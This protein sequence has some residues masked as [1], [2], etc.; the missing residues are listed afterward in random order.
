MELNNTWLTVLSACETGLSIGNLWSNESYSLAVG[1]NRGNAD[2][3]G[4]P[5]GSVTEEATRELLTKSLF[6]LN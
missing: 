5:Y 3:F 6:L 4:L 2:G 1:F